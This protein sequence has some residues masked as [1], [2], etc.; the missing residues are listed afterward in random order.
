[1]FVEACTK[2]NS[3]K[4]GIHEAD[5]GD[6]A[7]VGIGFRVASKA[8]NFWHVV[9]S[10]GCLRRIES[11]REG[12]RGGREGGGREERR[13]GGEEEGGGGEGEREGEGEEMWAW[14]LCKSWFAGYGEVFLLQGICN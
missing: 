4:F 14:L 7:V 6:S 10:C 2:F 9:N 8:R 13:E 5:I 3:K 12:R 1:M 11:K